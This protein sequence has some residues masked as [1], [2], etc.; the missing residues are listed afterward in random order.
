MKHLI[1][2]GLGAALAL[3][4]SVPASAQALFDGCPSDEILARFVEFGRSGMMP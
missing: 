3:G 1:A 4:L 2:K